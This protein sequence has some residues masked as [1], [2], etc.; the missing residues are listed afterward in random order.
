MARVARLVIPGM[1]HH[2]TQRGNRRQQTF[3]SGEDYAS[4][5]ESW[6]SGAAKRAWIYGAIASCPI[7]ST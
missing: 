5:V 4:Y 7:T 3:F 1:P 6:P 2:V